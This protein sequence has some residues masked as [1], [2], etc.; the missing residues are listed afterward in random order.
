MLENSL[1][2]SKTYPLFYAQ[3]IILNYLHE[4]YMFHRNLTYFVFLSQKKRRNLFLVFYFFVSSLL[5]RQFFFLVY[6][7]VSHLILFSE[8]KEKAFCRQERTRTISLITDATSTEEAKLVCGLCEGSLKGRS[9][10]FE[11]A[12]SAGELSVVAVLVCGHVYHADCLEQK[13]WHEDIRD[14]LCPLCAGRSQCTNRKF[15]SQRSNN[16]FYKNLAST[17]RI[18]ANQAVVY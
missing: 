1:I 16:Q 15:C 14:P 18:D 5:F 7:T 6:I 4:V 9:C 13:T 11:N 17:R 2:T 12:I 3:E 8:K 10:I